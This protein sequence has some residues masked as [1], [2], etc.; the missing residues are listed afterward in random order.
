MRQ[1]ILFVLTGPSGAGKGTV[2]SKVVRMLPGLAYSVS[3]TTRKPRAGEIDGIHYFFKTDNEFDEMVARGE[4]LECVNK[5]KH[6]Y[7]T[8]VRNVKEQ[9]EK[10]VDVILEIE[11]IGASKIRD[12]FPDAVFIF[13]TP[14]TYEELAR[15]LIMRGTEREEML[16]LRLRTAR[17]EYRSIV[18]YEYI[19][20]NDDLDRCID[21]VISIM[22]AERSKKKNNIELVNM[23]SNLYKT[24]KEENK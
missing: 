5:F 13:I 8:P 14:S 16:K 10:G 19:A 12:V 3:V 6:K 23:Y 17:T 11:T 2:L 4:F 20:I 9:L 18:E 21:T 15:R 24:Y 22:K 1:G 7:G